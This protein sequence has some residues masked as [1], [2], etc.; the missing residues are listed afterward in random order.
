MKQMLA[1]KD[2]WMATEMP[3][4]GEIVRKVGEAL[5]EKK[6]ELG[7]IVSLEMGKIL[8]EG[9]GEVQEFIDMCDYA[10]G[11]SRILSGKIIQS[12]RKEHVLLEHW[13]PLG[14]I[15]VISAFNFPCAV[16]GWNFCISMICGNCMIWKGA[17]STSLVTISLTRLIHKV[18]KENNVP[19][20]VLTS[21]V[22]SGRTVGELFLHDKR[23]ELVSFTGSTPIG[24]RVSEKVHAR[25]GRTILELGG[26]NCMIVCEDADLDNAIKAALFSAVGTAGQRCTSLRRLIIH[27][28]HYDSFVEKLVKAYGTVK[29]GSSLEKDTLL[30]PLH[31]KAAIK[32]YLEGL[33]EIKKQGGKI[34]TGGK[35]HDTLKEGNFV[36]P[37]IVEIDHNAK[38]V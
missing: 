28:K 31:N 19:D 26:N 22:G 36:Y 37:T 3:F 17:S 27:E 32:E 18:L 35:V 7:R 38:I 8:S 30:G 24:R 33:E 25:F 2:Q 10:C 6:E 4:R 1:V 21:I 5:R 13:N 29:I 16:F 12:E 20:G 15:G 14:I 9:L 11:L 34:L 23:L